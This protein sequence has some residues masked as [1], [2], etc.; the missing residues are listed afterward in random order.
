M[1]SA[2]AKQDHIETAE[3]LVDALEDS[4]VSD[5][6]ALMTLDVAAATHRGCVRLR[7]EDHYLVMRFRRS[8]EKPFD[9]SRLR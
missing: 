7:K 2:S 5:P 6:G 8:L 4:Y 3:L 1:R 9:E